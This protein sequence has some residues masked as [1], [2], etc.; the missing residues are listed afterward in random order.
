MRAGVLTHESVARLLNT[1]FVPLM[2]DA[3]SSRVM[4]KRLRKYGY[5]G[6]VPF[7]AILS[8][9]GKR[10]RQVPDPNR[11]LLE[12]RRALRV[13]PAWRPAG[14]SAFDRADWPEAIRQAD[15]DL[16]KGETAGRLLRAAAARIHSAPVP[17][18]E[19]LLQ[20]HFFAVRE[21]G[22]PD[23][24]RAEQLLRKAL[25]RADPDSE[26]AD[27][28]LVEAA[29]LELIRGKQEAARGILELALK[30]YP[31]SDRRG[32]AYYWL[33]LIELGKDRASALAIW[34]KGRH[35]APD[36]LW[37]LRSKLLSIGGR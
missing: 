9:D 6:G 2:A 16:E 20:K 29:R 17:A 30:A 14:V 11:V 34:Q 25:D 10:L 23:L 33:G 21:R 24:D 28:L 22:R 27:D 32:E 37:S 4:K 7:I 1:S 35:S 5:A 36:S 18:E 19:T 26:I 3:G 8:P 15:R 12:L 13:H 31:K